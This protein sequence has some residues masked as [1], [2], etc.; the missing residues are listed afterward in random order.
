MIAVACQLKEIHF[1]F[2]LF[3]SNNPKAYY[4]TGP[5]PSKFSYYVIFL[6]PFIMNIPLSIALTRSFLAWPPASEFIVYFDAV[7][8]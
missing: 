5:H 4:T 7:T 6:Q 8:D 1:L 2:T 3:T